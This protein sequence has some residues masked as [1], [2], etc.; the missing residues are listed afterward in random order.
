MFTELKDLPTDWI[1]FAS[2]AL[3]TIAATIWQWFKFRASALEVQKAVKNTAPISN[4][5]VPGIVARLDALKEL[6][7]ERDAR[8]ERRHEENLHRFARI[9]AR[10]GIDDDR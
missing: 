10:L 2:L 3:V 1:G 5:T 7:Q 9:E 6:A 8:D 4:G